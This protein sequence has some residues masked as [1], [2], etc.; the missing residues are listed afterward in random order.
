MSTFKKLFKEKNWRLFKKGDCIIATSLLGV[1][2][3]D[4]VTSQKYLQHVKL[5]TK[6]NMKLLRYEI[7]TITESGKVSF[8]FFYF[9]GGNYYVKVNKELRCYFKIMRL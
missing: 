6:V 1:L 9:K 7:E 5:I 2:N 3:N 4:L 8:G